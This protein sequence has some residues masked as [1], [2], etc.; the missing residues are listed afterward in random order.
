MWLQYRWK[1]IKSKQ[2]KNINKHGQFYPL[3]N[4][5]IQ[6]SQS[7]INFIEHIWNIMLFMKGY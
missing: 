2:A 6:N 5:G 4:D 1:L 7:E 3:L